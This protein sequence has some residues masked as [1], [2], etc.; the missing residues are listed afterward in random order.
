MGFNIIDMLKHVIGGDG[1]HGYGVC[2]QIGN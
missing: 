1:V 2:A